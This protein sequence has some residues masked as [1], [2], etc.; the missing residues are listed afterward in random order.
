MR[1]LRFLL[2]L[3]ALLAGVASRGAD[4]IDDAARTVSERVTQPSPDVEQMR[5][6]ADCPVS[7][8]TGSASFSV[9]LVSLST[10]SCGVSLGLTY[11]CE[12]KKVTETAGY[13]G[14]G[15]TQTGLGSVS[16]QICGMPDDCTTAPLDFQTDSYDIDYYN[17]LLDRKKDGNPDRYTLVTPDGESVSFIIDGLITLLNYTELKIERTPVADNFLATESFT[18]TTPEGVVYEYTEKETIDYIS[19]LSPISIGEYNPAYS[20]VTSWHLTKITAPEKSDSII[21]NYAP[22]TTWKRCKVN[23]L[24]VMTRSWGSSGTTT[25]S[26]TMD[27]THGVMT[28]ART[29]FNTPPYP[30]SIVSKNGT[31]NLDFETSPQ[32]ADFN[33]TA[34][35]L[36]AISLTDPDGKQVKRIEFSSKTHSRRRFLDKLTFYADESV[37]DSYNFSYFGDSKSAGDIFGYPNRY[38]SSAADRESVLTEKLEI[39][40]T[41]RIDRECL[42]TGLLKSIENHQGNITTFDYEPSVITLEKAGL[43]GQEVAV[44]T[45]IK[46]ITTEDQGTGRKRY[47]EFSY[48]DPVCDI[49]LNAFC[50]STFLAPN[51]TCNYIMAGNQKQYSNFS[52]SV[53]FTA[54]ARSAGKPLESAKIYYGA[55]EEMISDGGSEA[56]LKKRYEYDLSHCI[57]SIKGGIAVGQP[58][59]A[60]QKTNPYLYPK[61]GS[62]NLNDIYAG[63][64]SNHAPGMAYKEIFGGE[65]MLLRKISYTTANGT[66]T[67]HITEVF[68]YHTQ[69]L[70]TDIAVGLQYE[71]YCYRSYLGLGINGTKMPI[72]DIAYMAHAPLYASYMR[73]VCTGKKTTRHYDDGKS[74][75]MAEDYVYQQRESK[76]PADDNGSF[77]G[78]VRHP[79]FY[80]DSIPWSGYK[81]LFYFRPRGVTYSCNGDSLTRYDLYSNDVTSRIFSGLGLGYLPVAKKWVAHGAAYRDSIESVVHY[82]RFGGLT[83]PVMEA[84]RRHGAVLDS[85]AYT[86]YNAL[87]LPT[88]SRRRDGTA[89]GYAWTDYG[90]LQEKY[91]TGDEARTRVKYTHLPLIGCNSITYPS[92]RKKSFDYADGRV[93]AVRNTAGDITERYSYKFFGT[94][95]ENS[96]TKTKITASGE[97]ASRTEYDGY[98]MPVAE[99]AVGFGGDGGD[100]TTRTDYDAL[101]RPVRQW[102]PLPADDSNYYGDRRPYTDHIYD[103]DGSK[104]IISTTAP[105]EDLEGHA[106][107]ARYI[108]NT[109]SGELAARRLRI[110]G[111]RLV[112]SGYHPAATLDVV[113]ATDADGHTTLSFSDWRGRTVLTRKVLVE[114][115]YIDTYT[116][117]NLWGDVAL[118]LQPMGAAKLGDRS[119]DISDGNMDDLIEEYAYVYR[120]DEALRPVYAKMPGAAPVTTVYD[121]DGL[122]AYTSDG[123]LRADGKCRFNLYDRLARPVLTGVCDEPTAATGRMRA[124]YDSSVAGLDSTGYVSDI[125]LAGAEVYTATYYDDYYHRVRSH[126]ADMPAEVKARATSAYGLVTGTLERVMGSEPARFAASMSLYDKE[127]RPT[128][129]MQ[130]FHTPG[131]CITTEN[132]YNIDGSL[133]SSYFELKHPSSS[134]DSTYYYDYDAWGRLVRERLSYDWGMP[135]TLQQIKYNRIGQQESNKLLFLSESYSYDVRGSL[136]KRSSPVFEQ[137]VSNQGQFSRYYNGSIGSI[138]DKITGGA[139][140]SNSYTYDNAGRLTSAMIFLNGVGRPVAYEYDLNGNITHLS[141]R[142]RAGTS[143]MEYIDLLDYT[144]EGNRVVKIDDAATAVISESTMNFADGVDLDTEYAYDANGNM[145]VDSNK[146]LKYEWDYNNMLRSATRTPFFDYSTYTRTATGTRLSRSYTKRQGTPISPAIDLGTRPWWP[147]NKTETHTY[148]TYGP[149]EFE[150]GKFARFNN[151]IG[152]IDS[153]EHVYIHDWQGNVRAVVHQDNSGATVLDQTTYYYPYGMPMAESTSPDANRYKYTAKELFTDSRL[154]LAD[155]GARM[156]DPAIGRWISQD[157]MQELRKD[158]TSYNFCL[159]NPISFIDNDGF[160]EWPVNETYNGQSRRHSNDFGSTKDRT[161]PHKGVD[162]NIGSGDHDLGAPVLATHEGKVVGLTYYTQDS[163]PGGT[164]LHIQSP[165]GS[166]RTTYMHLSEVSEGIQKDSYIQEGQEIGKIGG[167]GK[168]LERGQDV[169]L[170]YEIR[171]NGELINPAINSTKLVDAQ[172]LTKIDNNTYDGGTL[173]GVEVVGNGTKKLP[174]LLPKKEIDNLPKEITK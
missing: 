161:S 67:P 163:N 51:G 158:F 39:R 33:G 124:R 32:S 20:A 59:F 118:V 71:T 138:N 72:E 116:L 152:Y 92:G 128:V 159:Q 166:V 106:A 14:L 109:A 27:N 123:N 63:V 173:S 38:Y 172:K 56:P 54:S 148:D 83:R 30:A 174:T 78:V 151:T 139:N 1:F 131:V 142:G 23:D 130:T 31:I 9:P 95:T 41:R 105:G 114:G 112:C 79:G 132:E 111:D 50:I 44:G 18:V 149:Y 82:G 52:M 19:V 6:Y 103:L 74:R 16:R 61:G 168:G 43:L 126:F 70:T 141:R 129:T 58:S 57:S 104:N 98:G 37:V 101:D 154:N 15:W 122:V 76:I 153:V 7:Y 156:Y 144:Y 45:R 42:S 102:Q 55:V 25:G 24:L 169:H 75:V 137:T 150:D 8:A 157:P 160:R 170:H 90:E 46:S 155:H 125:T 94:D 115:K 13:V 143:S 89:F 2:L 91:A 10:P 68:S 97:A 3:V 136:V 21:I 96:I 5:Q 134:S 49:D 69:K 26:N 17:D 119:Y 65:P 28:E 113:H 100:V 146:G 147:T 62:P 80:N 171:L 48:Y 22:G 11:R 99:V 29:T 117:Y 53:T 164:R 133:S 167:S 140:T 88:A 12:A 110:E 162:I 85:V 120:Y 87:G 165:D 34:D 121:P 35:R 86:A 108:C 81:D 145:L 135:V 60:D 36:S 127:E 73:I 77:F 40:N 47:R 107:T 4:N 93:S 84:V 64:F 66:Y